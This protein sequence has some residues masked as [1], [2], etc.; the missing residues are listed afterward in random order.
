MNDTAPT[1]VQVT[2]LTVLADF[3]PAQATRENFSMRHWGIRFVASLQKRTLDTYSTDCGTTACAAGW[4][5]MVPS[6]QKEGL[7]MGENGPEYL[8]Y[9]GHTALQEFFG[10]TREQEAFLFDSFDDTHKPLVLTP[11]QWSK[12]CHKFLKSL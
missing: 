8:E 10:L 4:A 9:V 1:K 3:I 2:R 5:C 6:F 11:R 7:I 12:R